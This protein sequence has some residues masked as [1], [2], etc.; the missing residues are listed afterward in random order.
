MGL[1]SCGWIFGINVGK[2]S[3]YA[4]GSH[5][6]EIIYK[7]QKNSGYSWMYPGLNVL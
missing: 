1:V 4:F 7:A 5:Q 3:I 6:L 2:H